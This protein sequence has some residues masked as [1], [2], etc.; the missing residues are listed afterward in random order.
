M[1]MWP[2]SIDKRQPYISFYPSEYILLK[3]KTAAA[4]IYI[5]I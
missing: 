5:Y 4:N 3:R 1:G 2:V